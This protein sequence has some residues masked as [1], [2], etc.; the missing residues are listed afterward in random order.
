MRLLA[1]RLLLVVCALLAVVPAT[2]GAATTPKVTSVAP[3][4]LK[5]GERLTI[6]GS[7]FVPGKN[8]N[9][10]VFKA[11]GQRAVFAKAVSATKTRL[12]VKV[13]AKLAS[14]LK[15]KAGQPVA[16]RFQLRVLARKLSKAYTPAKGSPTIAPAAAAAPAKTPAAAAAPPAAPA[17]AAAPAPATAPALTAYE[18]CQAAAA[19][20]PAGDQDADGMKNGDERTFHMNPCDK[21]GDGDGMLDGYEYEA[22]R[23]LASHSSGVTGRPFPAI[24]PWPNPMEAS[25][26]NHDFDGDGLTL[27]EE[28]D[29]WWARGHHFPITEYSDGFQATGGPLSAAGHEQLDLNGNGFLSDDERDAD[30]DGL[31]NIVELHRGGIESW[32]KDVQE[33]TR[34]TLRPFGVIDPTRWDSDGDGVSDGAGDQDVD[35]FSNFTEMQLERGATDTVHTTKYIVDPFNP[36]MPNPHADTC[37]RYLPFGSDAWRPFADDEPDALI[38]DVLPFLNGPEPDHLT[39]TGDVWNGR[40]A[41]PDA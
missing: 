34:Y 14:F 31:S 29:L 26:R 37:S 3:L 38:G 16:T 15:A 5:I 23:D 18:Q 2:A 4:N 12:V 21:D 22:A 9:T 32:W 17:A 24:R 36:C 41:P 11:T 8:R 1:F 30:L 20:N 35:G 25:D 7:G 6:K 28:Y 13:P 27:G 33:E 19:A 10:V 40:P 39:W